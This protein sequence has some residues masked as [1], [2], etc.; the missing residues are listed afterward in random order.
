MLFDRERGGGVMVLCARTRTGRPER[1]KTKMHRG[2]ID[3][4]VCQNAPKMTS[5]CKTAVW[6]QIAPI[7]ETAG[8]AL[9][10]PP[11]LP[12]F[13]SRDGQCAARIWPDG[14]IPEKI[15][16]ETCK[17]PLTTVGTRR[18]KAANAQIA[19]SKLP[20]ARTSLHACQVA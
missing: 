1:N 10:P 19:H 6:R 9:S 17:W 14:R 15:E 8:P 4:A 20:V 7:G 3:K 12:S 2:V 13:P 5:R 18:D 11:P 16:N